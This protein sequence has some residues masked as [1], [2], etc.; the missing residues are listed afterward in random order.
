MSNKKVWFLFILFFVLTFSFMEFESGSFSKKSSNIS[1]DVEQFLENQV[2]KEQLYGTKPYYWRDDVL[3]SVVFDEQDQG[4]QIKKQ[5]INSYF[6]E[7]EL[8]TGLVVREVNY[9]EANVKLIFAKDWRLFLMENL[10]EYKQINTKLKTMDQQSYRDYW[11]RNKNDN[12]ALKRWDSTNREI[13]SETIFFNYLIEKEECSI[14]TNISRTLMLNPDKPKEYKTSCINNQLPFME[15]AFL[16]VYY[17]DKYKSLLNSSARPSQEQV[18]KLFV[19]EMK[20]L[21]EHK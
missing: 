5:R 11:M 19:N 21:I 17:G 12:Y 18:K 3:Y 4:N 1:L 9:S 16:M 15:K 20:K 10:P 13:V 7:L 8:I 14:S 6:K 2:S